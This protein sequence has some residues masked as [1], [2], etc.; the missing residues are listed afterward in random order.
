[1]KYVLMV[2]WKVDRIDILIEHE[3]NTMRSFLNINFFSLR[4]CYLSIIDK[5]IPMSRKV[6]L[7][8]S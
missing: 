6:I 2:M 1:M 7:S 4:P 3:R 5:E 8:K